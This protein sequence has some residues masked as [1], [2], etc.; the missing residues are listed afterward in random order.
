MI[1]LD[2]D[3]AILGSGFAGSITALLCERIGRSVVLIDRQSHPRFAIGESS[4]PIADFVLRDLA[5]KYDLLRLAP[6][7][8]YGTWQ[9][10]YPEI[11]CGLKR[12]FSYFRHEPNEPFTPAKRHR[13]E[14]LV[15]ASSDD[16]HA[17]THWLRADV[18]GFL[19]KEVQ[20]S[21]VPF[22]DHTQVTPSS[23]GVV[24]RLAGHRNEEPVYISARFVIDATGATG[25]ILKA[26]A[27][28]W[29]TTSL[30]TNSRAIYGHFSGVRP[31]RE[32]LA[33]AGENLDEH[34]FRCDRSALHQIV[35]EGWMWQ[36]RFNN[37]ITSAGV[38]F[39]A[40][41]SEATLLPAERRWNDWLQ[42]YPSLSKQF[43]NARLET[44]ATGL[45][46]TGRMQ[47]LAARFVG[48]NWALLPHTAGF[49]D[50]L[51]STG[52]AHSLCGVERLVSLLECHWQADSL[53]KQLQQYERTL[54]NEFALIDKLVCGC[55]RSRQLFPAFVAWTMLYFAAATTYEQRRAQNDILPG[56]A[57]LCADDSALTSTVDRL[58]ARLHNLL[59][60]P[61]S[62]QEIEQFEQDL[63]AAIRPFNTAGLCD[64]RANNLYR[65]T[66]APRARRRPIQGN[67]SAL[68][69]QGSS[70]LSK[71]SP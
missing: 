56:A 39:D 59:A 64:P 57:F 7:S 36:L 40:T 17:D 1:Q 35:D 62:E 49:I 30:L 15:A 14:L 67:C 25:P 42:S 45:Q 23:D 68:Q 5:H 61:A 6:L 27:I 2:A 43:A 10:A 66:A 69:R 47:R 38:V 24:W 22:L 50:P 54:R 13:N 20:D 3:I 70:S 32:L 52:I 31:W 44:P 21:R 4:T 48:R 19:A 63:A 53:D 8:S 16:Y 28:P 11:G 12:G 29:Q 37:G 71:S 51:H 9:E 58:W 55:Y 46:S 18:D 33:V 60:G 41:T 65:Y 26:L 34:P